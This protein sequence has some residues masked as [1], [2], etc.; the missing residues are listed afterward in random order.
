M[1][2]SDFEAGAELPHRLRVLIVPDPDPVQ[3]EC[4]APAMLD[5]P[6]AMAQDR[7]GKDANQTQIEDSLLPNYHCFAVRSR[8][9][10]AH[11]SRSIPNFWTENTMVQIKIKGL[12]GGAP[13]RYRYA[14]L[15]EGKRT[16]GSGPV[17][18]TAK[19][20]AEKLKIPIQGLRVNRGGHVFPLSASLS[21]IFGD[22]D[23]GTFDFEKGRVNEISIEHPLG[24][25]KAFGKGEQS[26]TELASKAKLS[27]AQLKANEKVLDILEGL[28]HYES[29]ALFIGHIL[30]ILEDE[31][32]VQF[33]NPAIQVQQKLT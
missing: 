9:G 7:D 12:L 21:E 19:E 14:T 3:P 27:P 11:S 17:I 30:R 18:Q 29:G 33:P 8:T 1:D 16:K 32:A 22:E 5:Q 23:N 31:M 26:F 13:I 15:F 24:V 4:L 10:F 2:G 25:W 20:I 6:G 28:A